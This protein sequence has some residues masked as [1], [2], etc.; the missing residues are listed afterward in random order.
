MCVSVLG[1]QI[2][3]IVAILAF[4]LWSVIRSTSS[5]RSSDGLGPVLRVAIESG[6]IYTMTMS[7]GL[8]LFLLRSRAVYIIMD[9]VRPIPPFRHP[10]CPTDLPPCPRVLRSPRPPSRSS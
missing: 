10:L 8:I 6:I 9:I 7:A 1:T 4:K 2:D 5:Y 3:T